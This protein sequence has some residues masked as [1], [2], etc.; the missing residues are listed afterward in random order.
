MMTSFLRSQTL[1]SWPNSRL[2]MP[3]VPG[4]QTSWVMRTSTFTQTL[5]P[6]WT[7]ALPL[8]RAR[9]FSVRVINLRAG[10]IGIP[11]ARG[12]W[13]VGTVAP[14]TPVEPQ[15]RGGA[16]ARNPFEEMIEPQ[17]NTD[18]ARILGV[19]CA[20]CANSIRGWMTI[21]QRTQRDGSE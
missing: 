18:R 15:R 10:T 17:I 8:A 3:I 14:A 19:L 4:P 2:K 11:G 5:S 9:T 7:C 16:E 13:N 21:A 6:G 1:A 12:K 20:L